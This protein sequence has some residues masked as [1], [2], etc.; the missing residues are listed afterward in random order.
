MASQQQAH[1]TRLY[2]PPWG[3]GDSISHT[4]QVIATGKGWS[5]SSIRGAGWRTSNSTARFLRCVALDLQERVGAGS[6]RTA[7]AES[8]TMSR[9]DLVLYATPQVH[10]A[11]TSTG[12]AASVL[13][14]T[15][16]VV[17]PP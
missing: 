10:I 8:L 2:W 1:F 11:K 9:V 7:A 17:L 16:H 4:R 14:G 15:R 6:P 5:F 3:G 12:G 13:S